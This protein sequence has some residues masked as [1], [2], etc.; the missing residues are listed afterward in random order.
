MTDS[1][2]AADYRAAA[3]VARATDGQLSAKQCEDIADRLSARDDYAMKLGQLAV[4]GRGPLR[5]GASILQTLVADGWIIP[6]GLFPDPRAP[7][8]DDQP[9]PG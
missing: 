9:S 8:S 1:L 5:N 3:R 7:E 6:E 2:T 4:Q